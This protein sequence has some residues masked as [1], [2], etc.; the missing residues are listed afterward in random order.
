[1]WLQNWK[2]WKVIAQKFNCF[3]GHYMTSKDGNLYNGTRESGQ[4]L[5]QLKTMNKYW[6]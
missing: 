4:N 3:P 2:H 5:M 6:R 1:M